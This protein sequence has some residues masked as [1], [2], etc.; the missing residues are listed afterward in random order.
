MAVTAAEGGAA[1]RPGVAAPAAL[2]DRFEIAGAKVAPGE[3]ATL[4][5]QLPGQSAFTPLSM[6]LHV[7]HGRKA[8]PV[9]FVS[10]AI[11]GDE[12]N[13][14]EIIRQLRHARA[15]ARLRGTLVCIPIVNMYGFLNN[16]RYLPDR[17]DLNRSFPGSARGSLA[18]RIAHVFASEIVARASH[19]IDLH[20]GGNHRT[21]LPHI[22]ANLDHG[23]T[24][25]LA[26]SFGA[27]VI[28]NAN[29]RDGSL[30]QYALE[31]GLTMLLY[32]AGEALRFDPL[33]IAAGLRGVLSVMTEL[34]MLPPR[35]KA[36]Q[37]A[38]PKRP[39]AG[40]IVARTSQWIRAP[41]SGLARAA[42]RLGQRV[43]R[44]QVLGWIADA[45]GENEVA[46]AAPLTGIVIGRSNLP[47]VHEGDALF[48]IAGFADSGRA[49]KA[50]ESFQGEHIEGLQTGD[51]PGQP[52]G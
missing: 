50:I 42:A 40:P 8:G 11:H 36:P 21:N 13:G 38:A 46:V 18:A 24:E 28:I 41:Q 51:Y 20:T 34:E 9:L 29:L 2:R 39:A 49:E 44:G 1:A 16:T 32:E 15:L 10:A 19:G 14:V 4:S 37:A 26:R 45:V 43:E 25:R 5:L 3:R 17:R 33:S 52:P 7:V 31:K 27:P 35:R 47:A 23:D 6:P 30:R 48:H 12:I 22:R